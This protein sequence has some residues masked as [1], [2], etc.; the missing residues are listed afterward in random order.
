MEDK[1]YVANLVTDDNSSV[2]KML[3]HSYRELLEAFKIT[4]AEWPRYVNGR[5][6]SDNGLLPLLHAIS[7]FLA[8]KGHRVR[9]YT[10]FVFAELVKS[11]SNGCGCTKVD[12][13][14]MKRRL[15]WTL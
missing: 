8:D 6:M 5:N 3:T 12:A 14:R 7:K 15:S 9:G 10:R 11:I 1:C 4:E 13:E 2:R